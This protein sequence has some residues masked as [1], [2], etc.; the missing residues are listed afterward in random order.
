MRRAGSGSRFVVRRQ[1]AI[2]GEQLAFEE[3]REGDIGGIVGSHVGA[4]LINA[5]LIGPQKS[6]ELVT[7]GQAAVEPGDAPLRLRFVLQ[8]GFFEVPSEER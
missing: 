4:Q 3:R 6:T 1:P 7:Q 2:A 5:S 8:C